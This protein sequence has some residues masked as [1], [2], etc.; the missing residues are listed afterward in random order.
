MSD[1][2]FVQAATLRARFGLKAPDALHLA[3]TIEVSEKGAIRRP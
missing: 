1:D 2:V 3:T